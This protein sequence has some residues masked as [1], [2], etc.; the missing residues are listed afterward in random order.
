MKRNN[1]AR[2]SEEIEKSRCAEKGHY[3][4][5]KGVRK[6]EESAPRDSSG[7]GEK[8]FALVHGKT[9]GV[10]ALRGASSSVVNYG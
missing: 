5:R 7:G 9:V 3:F 1:G 2:A 10:S 8:G 6:K 4:A